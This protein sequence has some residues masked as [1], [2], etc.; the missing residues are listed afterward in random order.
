[1]EWFIL[2]Y[3]VIC[4]HQCGSKKFPPGKSRPNALFLFHYKSC[5]F[6]VG[7]VTFQFNTDAGNEFA[8]PIVIYSFSRQSDAK[9]WSVYRLGFTGR[10][11]LES[12]FYLSCCNSCKG[13]AKCC[14]NG[15]IRFSDNYPT[16]HLVDEIIQCSIC[17]VTYYITNNCSF[18]NCFRYNG[19]SISSNSVSISLERLNVY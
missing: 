11:E 17:S 3:P 19:Y 8:K 1:M 14:N 6:C 9:G 10:L 13:S 2:G 7:Q 15:C 4:L 18:I 12:C 16:N 5:K